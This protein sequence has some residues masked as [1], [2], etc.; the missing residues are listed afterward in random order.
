M[1]RKENKYQFIYTNYS[2]F[3]KAVRLHWI[4]IMK[5]LTFHE[6]LTLRLVNKSMKKIFRKLYVQKLE[7]GVKETL[8]LRWVD[9][10]RNCKKVYTLECSSICSLNKILFQC[11]QV[12]LEQI[13]LN[14]CIY[15]YPSIG[16]S[17]YLQIG[18]A[19][20]NISTLKTI[21]LSVPYL[22]R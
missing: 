4:L 3:A 11:N 12:K 17:S 5:Y 2:S 10:L 22:H 9:Y 15:N 14:K 19:L 16:V 6:C 21:H 18:K 13:Y 8:T 1:S 20:N 7:I